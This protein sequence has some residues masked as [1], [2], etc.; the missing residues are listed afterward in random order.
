MYIYCVW[1][2]A[3]VFKKKFILKKEIVHG[4]RL[5]GESCGQSE[6]EREGQSDPVLSVEP[7]ARLDH[8]PE[9]KT[10]SSG[11]WDHNRSWNQELDA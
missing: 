10:P 9:I 4:T 7:D 6:R 3:R 1:P 11:P 8:N 2:L 5:W